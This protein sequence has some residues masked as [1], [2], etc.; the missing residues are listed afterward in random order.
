M[1]MRVDR[2][3]IE[4][5]MPEQPDSAAAACV[6]E[7]LGGRF[8]EMSTFMNYTFQ[9]WNFR[10]REKVRP[11]YELIADIGTE[12]Y[13][14]FELVAST[15]NGMLTGALSG[16]NP[17]DTPLSGVMP[18]PSPNH[19]I[20][21]GQTAMVGNSLGSPGRATTCSTRATWCSTSCT[22]S[23]ASAVRARTRSASTR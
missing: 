21:D 23:S 12:E 18:A 14:H 11:Y 15:I 5:D 8:G 4:M 19:F 22:T 17:T 20:V 3:Q 7:L 13:G 6:Q 2:L 10:G 9:S 1:I 16:G